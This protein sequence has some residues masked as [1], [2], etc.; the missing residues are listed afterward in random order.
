MNWGDPEVGVTL[1]MI[2]WPVRIRIGCLKMC[3]KKARD[4]Y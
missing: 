2:R 1:G 3:H 4:V